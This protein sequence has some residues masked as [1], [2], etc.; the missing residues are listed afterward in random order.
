MACRCSRELVLLT[1]VGVN[2]VPA[3][4]EAWFALL[5]RGEPLLLYSPVPT[6]I[7]LHRSTRYYPRASGLSKENSQPR[8]KSATQHKTL[9]G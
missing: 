9:P 4:G 5:E 3:E 6:N 8:P 7:F 1:L 2:F